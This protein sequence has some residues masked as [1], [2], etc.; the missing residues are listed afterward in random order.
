[1]EKSGSSNSEDRNVN[2]GSEV[3]SGKN[4]NEDDEENSFFG[5]IISDI[6]SEILFGW[7]PD[8]S[9]KDKEEKTEVKSIKEENKSELKIV[10]E[11]PKKEPVVIT[12]PEWIV[13]AVNELSFYRGEDIS[14][15]NKNGI[16]L[17]LGVPDGGPEYG[18]AFYTG[19]Y[20]VKDSFKYKDNIKLDGI[21]GI[22]LS[23]KGCIKKIRKDVGINAGGGLEMQSIYWKYKNPLYSETKQIT[24]DQIGAGGLYASIGFDYRKDDSLY[25][26]FDIKP[27]LFLTE[28]NTKQGFKNDVFMQHSGIGFKIEAGYAF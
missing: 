21:L 15:I 22:E 14:Y 18:V 7:I 24:E 17:K 5:S 8:G 25:L 27:K 20:G 28:K 16:S 4:Y 1:M 23:G 10:K 26:N 3:Y 13:A 11:T 2:T 9:S 12:N 19:S 6:F